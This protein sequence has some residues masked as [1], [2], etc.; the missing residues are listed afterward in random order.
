M[1]LKSVDVDERATA[2]PEDKVPML[3]LG[4]V[5]VGFHDL[6]RTFEISTTCRTTPPSRAM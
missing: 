3:S 6:V 1:N 2:A 4:S 5:T